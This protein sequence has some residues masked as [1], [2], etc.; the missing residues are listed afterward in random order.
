MLAC[1]EMEML[2][3]HL[4]NPI[5]HHVRVK[6][7]M[8]RHSLARFFTRIDHRAALSGHRARP[9]TRSPGCSGRLA[10]GIW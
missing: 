2:N 4:H 6:F 1:E 9:T 3:L 7:A 10:V 8:S 5:M